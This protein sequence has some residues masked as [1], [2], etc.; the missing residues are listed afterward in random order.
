M[1]FLG[2]VVNRDLPQAHNLVG[3]SGTNIFPVLGNPD[4][5]LR[6]N[7]QFGLKLEEIIHSIGNSMKAEPSSR[8]K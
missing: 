6:E 5:R 1:T 8:M 4:G 3:L 7:L 2:L